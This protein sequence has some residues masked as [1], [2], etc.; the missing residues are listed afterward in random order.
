M[1]MEKVSAIVD[2]HL[3]ERNHEVEMATTFSDGPSHCIGILGLGVVHSDVPYTERGTRRRPYQPS[4]FPFLDDLPCLKSILGP[5]E[6]PRRPIGLACT[7]VE[8]IKTF[9]V[10]VPPA[11]VGL[12]ANFAATENLNESRIS[13]LILHVL[14]V[15]RPH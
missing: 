11:R 8:G 5:V 3:I 9:D 14:D 2:L 12:V 10:E 6:I 15:A 7:K 13:R 1:L 4:R